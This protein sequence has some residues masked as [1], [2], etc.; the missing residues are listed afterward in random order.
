MAQTDYRKYKRKAIAMSTNKIK[1]IR[2]EKRLTQYALAKKINKSPW[3]I[4]IVERGLT[5]VSKNEKMKIAKV[6]GTKIEEVFS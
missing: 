6:L 3:W 1:Q 4:S 5:F 2:L